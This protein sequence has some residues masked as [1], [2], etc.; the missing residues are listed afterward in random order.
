MCY[1]EEVDKRFVLCM[2]RRLCQML[3]GMML[4]IKEGTSL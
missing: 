2:G 4:V 3:L 1:N